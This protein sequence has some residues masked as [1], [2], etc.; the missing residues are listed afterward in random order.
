[1]YYSCFRIVATQ[2]FSVA[3]IQKAI[4]SVITTAP[5]CG[6][7]FIVNGWAVVK[8]IPLLMQRWLFTMVYTSAHKHSVLE[9]IDYCHVCFNKIA[10]S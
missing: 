3:M 7:V 6:S 2:P 9:I 5:G 1:M 8:R 4:H 10:I